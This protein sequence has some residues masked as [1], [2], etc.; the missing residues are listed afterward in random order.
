MIRV[1]LLAEGASYV[2]A[3]RAPWWLWLMGLVQPMA[4]AYLIAAV[5][6]AACFRVAWGYCAFQ[7]C[8]FCP[9][10]HVG[11]RDSSGCD[12]SGPV[13]AA[14]VLAPWWR[15]PFTAGGPIRSQQGGGIVSWRCGSGC[16][17]LVIIYASRLRKTGASTCGDCVIGVIAGVQLRCRGWE[18]GTIFRTWVVCVFR[19]HRFLSQASP[20]STTSC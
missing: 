5:Y 9:Y 3:C 17:W 15:Q 13:A 19:D 18:L 1:S 6:L 20:S 11:L 8:S 7:R 14:Q 12:L 16:S 2:V 4:Q 10:R